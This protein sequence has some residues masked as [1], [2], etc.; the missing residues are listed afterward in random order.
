MKK[1]AMVISPADDAPL[2]PALVLAEKPS[3]A[4]DEL[5]TCVASFSTEYN[6]LNCAINGVTTELL[7]QDRELAKRSVDEL[8]PLVNRMWMHL[9]QRGDLHALVSGDHSLTCELELLADV[10]T[11][12]RWYEAFSSRVFDAKSLRT[13]QRKLKKLRGSDEPETAVDDDAAES[14]SNESSDCGGSYERE[15]VKT[16]SELLAE[17]ITKVLDALVGKSIM[18]D[19]MR[20]RRAIGL[21]KDLQ[22]A[23]DEGFLIVATTVPAPKETVVEGE[24]VSDPIRVAYAT[25]RSVF[26]RMADTTDIESTL[27]DSVE[28]LILPM[29]D[30][31]PYMLVDTPYRPELQISVTLYR[32]GRARISAGDWVEFRGGDDRL[33]KQIGAAAALGRV[34]EADALSRPCVTWSNGTEWLKPNSLF[35]QEAVHVLFADQAASAYPE[36][37]STYSEPPLSK[38]PA[39]VPTVEADASAS[40]APS[41]VAALAA[42]A[43]AHGMEDARE[44]PI[45][46][47]AV[48]PSLGE[49]L[50][51]DDLLAHSA[52]PVTL[53]FLPHG[54]ATWT[55]LVPGKKYQVRPAPSGGYGIYEP[56]STLLLQ[57]FAEEDAARDAIDHVSASVPVA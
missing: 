5:A 8:L 44:N 9:S 30:Q 25:L 22:C 36:A 32:A 19:A 27:Q 49:S 45:M 41:A 53:G 7:E 57:L 13:M 38:P 1:K 3:G 2:S 26:N 14:D 33:T 51:E 34:V 52:G 23:L 21:V 15:E 56:R 17:H 46:S 11:W 55:Q 37:F 24:V 42:S 40:S 16:G 50:A 12:T 10:P 6:N 29:L 35:N 31:H 47:N 4:G 20:I 39:A 54:E 28:E 48:R 18:S 43:G